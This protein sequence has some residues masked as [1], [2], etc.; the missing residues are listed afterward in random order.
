[1]F[2]LLKTDTDNIVNGSWAAALDILKAEVWNGRL[3]FHSKI[4]TVN[5]S[6]E[7]AE[8]ENMTDQERKFI[9]GRNYSH[10]Y[11]RESRATRYVRG[12][13]CSNPIRDWENGDLE[14]PEEVVEI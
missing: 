8:S 3:S 5:G 10:N 4:G 14:V 7:G 11:P 1:M 9:F 13:S 2:L 6:T 12:Y